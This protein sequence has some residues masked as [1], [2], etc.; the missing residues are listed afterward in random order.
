V[1]ELIHAKLEKRAP[2]IVT[3]QPG[4]AKVINIMDALKKSVQQGKEGAPAKTAAKRGAASAKSSGK[5]TAKSTPKRK[6]A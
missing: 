4:T 5:K 2:E 3:E 1:W 6:S